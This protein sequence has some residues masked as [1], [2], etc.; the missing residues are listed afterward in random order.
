MSSQSPRCLRPGTVV[1]VQMKGLFRMAHHFALVS[2][3]AGPDGLPMV[4]ANSGETGGPGEQS[5][6]H[7]VKGRCYRAFYPSTL[8]HETVL[9]N[10]YAMFGTRY[11]LLH[12][13]CEHFANLCHGRPAQSHQV[14]GGMMLALGAMT[15]GA[16]ALMTA[17]SGLAGGI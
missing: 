10:A 2:D 8:P 3:R 4:V 14:R 16:L 1:T 17:L 5:W 7:F 6:T 12:W 15:L 9:Y 11:H 13:N